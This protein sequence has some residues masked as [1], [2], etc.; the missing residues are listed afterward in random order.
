MSFL[1]LLDDGSSLVSEEEL[2]DLGI[3]YK[4]NYLLY[5]IRCF[6]RKGNCR[7]HGFLQIG[8]CISKCFPKMHMLEEHMVPWMRNWRVG[9]GFMG[10][11]GAESLHARLN[12]TDNAYNNMRDRVERLRVV[13]Q[14]HHLQILPEKESLRPPPLKVK[15]R[16]DGN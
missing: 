13:L 16:K 3:L 15:K 7:F 1:C 6:R 14:N 9:C 4:I 8:I 11:Q 12:Y 2:I 10:E 5:F